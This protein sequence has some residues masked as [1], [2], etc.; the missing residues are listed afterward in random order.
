MAYPHRLQC[1]D[2]NGRGGDHGSILFRYREPELD[3]GADQGPDRAG[4]ERSAA[5]TSRIRA[6]PGHLPRWAG[7]EKQV[8]L[9][10]IL[11]L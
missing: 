7:K 1:M 5:G 3:F 10:L 9:G 8:W 4:E 6:R 11:G 2:G